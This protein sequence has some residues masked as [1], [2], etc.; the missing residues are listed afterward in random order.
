VVR[1]WW[2]FAQARVSCRIEFALSLIPSEDFKKYKERLKID[3]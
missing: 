1:F 3:S 2:S